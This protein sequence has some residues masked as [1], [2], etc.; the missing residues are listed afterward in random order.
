SSLDMQYY[1]W[2]NDDSG[3][4]VM[5]HVIDAANRGVR[6]RLIIDDI[7]TMLKDQSPKHSADW[8]MAELGTH[9]N[10]EVRLFNAWHERSKIARGFEY[11]AHADHMNQRMHNKL[12]IADNRAAIVG[13]RNIGNEYFGLAEDFNFR[14]LDVVGFGPVAQ[15]A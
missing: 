4:L 5:K 7:S 1:I 13:G 11:L 15:Q 6:V 14:D 9:P 10:I 3:G 2:W 8:K 12:L